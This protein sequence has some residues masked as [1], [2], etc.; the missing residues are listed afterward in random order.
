MQVVKVARE[1]RQPLLVRAQLDHCCMSGDTLIYAF[2]SEYIYYMQQKNGELCI[3]SE[4]PDLCPEGILYAQR[5]C[6]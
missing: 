6:L 5:A 4:W 2:V 3:S 1:K